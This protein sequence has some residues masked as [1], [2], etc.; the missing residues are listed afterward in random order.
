MS[1][2][3][4]TVYLL[5]VKV[6]VTVSDVNDNPPVFEKSLYIKETADDLSVGS[7][8]LQIQATDKDLGGNAN[9]TYTISDGDP[10]GQWFHLST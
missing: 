1:I 3:I 2:G 10:E 8:I 9:I 5:V 7:I 4:V 6:H